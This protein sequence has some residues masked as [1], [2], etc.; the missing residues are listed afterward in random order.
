[1]VGVARLESE[2]LRERVEAAIILLWERRPNSIGFAELCLIPEEVRPNQVDSFRIS[3]VGSEEVLLSGE[4]SFRWAGKRERDGEGDYTK[5]RQHR[6]MLTEDTFHEEARLRIESLLQTFPMPLSTDDI[7]QMSKRP[8]SALPSQA[9][10]SQFLD[11]FGIDLFEER[12]LMSHLI[13]SCSSAAPHAGLWH[14]PAT[15]CFVWVPHRLQVR[16]SNLEQK[17]SPVGTASLEEVLGSHHRLVMRSYTCDAVGVRPVLRMGLRSCDVVPLTL[18]QGVAVDPFALDASNGVPIERLEP[19]LS[20]WVLYYNDPSISRIAHALSTVT[21]GSL[22][23][24]S[25]RE[26]DVEEDLKI[27]L[28]CIPGGRLAQV[29]ARTFL[30]KTE[31]VITDFLVEAGPTSQ[32]VLLRTLQIMALPTDLLRKEGTTLQTEGGRWSVLDELD[33]RKLWAKW[34]SG[35]EG[36]RA[37]EAIEII[38]AM[39]DIEHTQ[40][41]L[42]SSS[43][44]EVVLKHPA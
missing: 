11:Y 24:N 35:L 3:L 16:L 42:P 4:D 43:I 39:A 19:T 6:F 34:A 38:R 5:Y 29:W 25:K 7:L 22:S 41:D 37:E 26:T 2:M 28:E 32:S 40:L 17:G 31:S 13:K 44:Y 23:S 9:T 18:L 27:L 33:I 12:G 8:E 14:N 10:S 1:L 21:K 36:S 15:D 30:S 20:G